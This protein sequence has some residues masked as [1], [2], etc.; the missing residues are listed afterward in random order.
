MVSGIAGFVQI[1]RCSACCSVNEITGMNPVHD[2]KDLSMSDESWCDW[3][4]LMQRVLR[5]YHGAEDSIHGPEHWRRVERFGLDIAEHTGA[6]RMVVRLFA[7]F[8]DAG[9]V[10]QHTDPGHGRR[11][12]ELARLLKGELF[13]LPAS[14]FDTLVYACT[15]HTDERFNDD[16]TIGA[17]WDADRLDLGRVGITPSPRFMNSD[18]AKRLAQKRENG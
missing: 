17:C 15:W 9:R 12:A 3:E 18:Y 11:G 4:A 2:E 14:A 5:H 1:R 6:D 7:W 13:D 8:H 16:P 10:N